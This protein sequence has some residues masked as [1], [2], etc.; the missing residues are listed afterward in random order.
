MDIVNE[1][2]MLNKYWSKNNLKPDE[3]MDFESSISVDGSRTS[4]NKINDFVDF[5]SSLS[6]D[7]SRT[8]E[9]KLN[10]FIDYESSADGSIQS[11]SKRE[12]GDSNPPNLST[13]GSN[14]EENS[15]M[16][17]NSLIAWSEEDESEDEDEDDED[18]LEERL[19]EL[20]NEGDDLYLK[21][22]NLQE[23]YD[24]LYEHVIEVSLCCVL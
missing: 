24:K 14:V 15:R 20:Q 23:R 13:R 18:E 9:N 7:G 17:E 1:L 12:N 4:E 6:I 5:E 21:K 11:E 22:R 16:S 8:D 19:D 3:Q 2:A 10:D